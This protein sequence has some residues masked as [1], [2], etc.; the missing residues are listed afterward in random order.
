MIG[1]VGVTAAT[2]G[3]DGLVRARGSGFLGN[4]GSDDL[5]GERRL[6]PRRG[7]RYDIRPSKTLE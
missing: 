4:R 1:A 3:R 7:P 5:R 6:R 2:T